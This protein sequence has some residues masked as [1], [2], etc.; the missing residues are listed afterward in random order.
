EFVE[1]LLSKPMTKQLYVSARL[2]TEGSRL[3]NVEASG[4]GV[5][6]RRFTLTVLGDEFEHNFK[7]P[8]PS[9]GAGYTKF[10]LFPGQTDKFSMKQLAVCEQ[11][12]DL[13]L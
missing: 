4:P 10:R 9:P 13:L 5:A 12:S 2:I 3:V 8:L 11:P 1:V 6:T 7:M